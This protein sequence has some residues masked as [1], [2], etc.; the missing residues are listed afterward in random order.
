MRA[1]RPGSLTLQSTQDGRRS[2]TVANAMR[3]LLALSENGSPMGVTEL[4]TRLSLGKSTVHL[5]LQTLCDAR[6]VE[7]DENTGRY[8]IG[9]GAFEVGT[10]ALEHLSLGVHL[11]PPMERFAELSK[12]AVSLAIRSGHRAVIVKR[13]E[14]THILRADIRVGT[15]MPL[16]RS[17]S[18][19]CLLA[20]LPSEK[21]D[22]LFPNERLPDVTPESL[23]TRSELLLELE[24][25]RQ[26]GYALNRNEFVLGV[27]AVAVPIRDGHER[28]QAALSIAGP[29]ARFDAE[30]WVEQLVRTGAEMSYGIDLYARGNAM[31]P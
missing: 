22:E 8:R 11:D 5:L 18:G 2:K 4:A 28:V 13:F 3:L 21:L 23:H 14:S 9:A 7:V 25:V 17:A 26:H 12:E 24:R 30:G 1:Q 15:R 29:T 10:A 16:H 27:A 19:K 31:R 20:Y 6:F